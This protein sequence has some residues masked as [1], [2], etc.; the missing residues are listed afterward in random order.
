MEDLE[1]SDQDE[2][3]ISN[4]HEDHLPP[5]DR[6]KG[7]YLFLTACFM[8]EALIW[9]MRRLI[10]RMRMWKYT[11]LTI[12]S[13][14]TFSYG[15]FQD[16]Y[17]SHEPFKS[18]GDIAVIGT[19]AMGISYMLLP[20]AFILLQALPR[21]K[22]WAAPIGFLIMCLAIA[23]SSFATNTGQ[24]IVSQ[25]VAYGIGASLAYAPTIIF[26]DDWFVQRKG[27]A[28]GI[29]WAGTGLSGVILPIVMQW[30]LNTYGHETALRVWAIVLVIMGGPLLFYVRPRLP[31]SRSSRT[32]P[33]DFRFLWDATFLIYETGNI[34]EAMGYF[35]PT[36]YLPTY[37][38]SLGANNIQATLTVMLFNLA[39]V[40]GCVIMGSMVD[41]YH[42]TTCILMSTVGST[43]AVFL[44]WGLSV[45]LAPLY[46]FCIFYGLFAGSFTSTW[47]AVVNEIRKKSPYVEP[48]IVFGVL[49]TGRGIGNIVSG[50]LSGALLDQNAW[51]GM[52]AK[53]YGS[54][55][56]PLIVFTGVSAFLG[57]LGV[58][59]RSSKRL[60]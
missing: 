31:I 8:L 54:G 56:G 28:F 57:G 30:L 38:R 2:L 26:M 1:V 46:I 49:S 11:Q 21:M 3:A 43:I 25:G 36:I 41:R 33:F 47:P 17:S 19:C 14:F 48:S 50:P 42:A 22:L 24:L 13:G 53:A 10:L 34:L 51:K 9:G 39:S 58:V 16:Y 12:V 5:V 29:M 7:A 18:S 59:A 15:V 32:R 37:A 60:S 55:Y 4:H 45:S 52:A 40:F 6:G 35:L 27:L 23:M 44:I 20:V